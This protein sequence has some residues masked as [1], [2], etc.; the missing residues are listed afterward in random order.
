MSTSTI[1][2]ARPPRP[3][4]RLAV[5]VE[6][7][8]GTDG[9]G[10]QMLSVLATLKELVGQGGT[11]TV[12]SDPPQAP[13]PLLPKKSHAAAPPDG[14]IRVFPET[15]IVTDGPRPVPLSRL[16]FD[17]L[18]FL[19]AR[20]DRVHTR[21]QL[22]EVV[23][24]VGRGDIGQRTVDVHVRRLRAKMPRLAEALVT[25]RGVGYRFDSTDT[26]ALISIRD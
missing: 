25:V 18:H 17:L 8:R 7:P 22:L 15:R 16:E 4:R 12:A 24:G 3:A 13:V 2:H 10:D 6:F 23:W 5:T 21:Q 11:V 1:T 19:I 26:V 14:G 9:L 20:P